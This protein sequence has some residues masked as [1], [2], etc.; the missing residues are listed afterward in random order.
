MVY[1]VAPYRIFIMEKIKKNRKKRWSN[2]HV[3][4]AAQNNNLNVPSSKIFF[5]NGK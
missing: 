1:G 4:Y 3:E 2:R 5:I